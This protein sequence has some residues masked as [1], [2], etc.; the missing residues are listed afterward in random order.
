MD[1]EDGVAHN[2]KADARATIVKALNTL[3]FDQSERLVRINPVGSGLEAED[4]AAVLPGRPDGVVVPK[5]GDAATVLWVSEQMAEFEQAQGWPVG[6]ITLFAIVETAR[7]IVNLRRIAGAVPR[8]AV[9]LFGAE[10]LTADI[11]AVRTPAG[12]EVFYARSAV[13]THAAAFNLQAIDMLNVDFHDLET[14]R[15]DAEQGAQM[16]FSGK[17]IIHPNQV[18]PVLAAFTPTEEE[19]AAARRIVEASRTHQA[20]G[21]GAFTMDGKMVDMPVVKAAEQVLARAGAAGKLDAEKG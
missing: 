7:G 5:V 10:D 14:L 12:W 3:D 13:V 16:G 15:A 2:R 1:L 8:L 21:R 11:G 18:A 20:A 9:L 4:L 17:Q 6:G 19:I